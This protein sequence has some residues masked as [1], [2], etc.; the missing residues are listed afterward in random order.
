MRLLAPPPAASR[1][2]KSVSKVHFDV[3]FESGTVACPDRQATSDFDMRQV[4][5]HDV[6]V[7]AYRWPKEVCGGCALRHSMEHSPGRA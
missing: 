7:K 3:D 2:R 6:L 5:G 4:I 1:A